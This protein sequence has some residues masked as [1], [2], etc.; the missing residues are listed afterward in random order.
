MHALSSTPTAPHG[1]A[2]QSWTSGLTAVLQR[3]WAAYLVWRS[4][5]AAIA[6]LA[7]MSDRELQDIGV[8]RCGIEQAVMEKP[9][10][11]AAFYR[12]TAARPGLEGI[13]P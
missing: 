6:E 5:Q 2:G 4:E 12:A 13:R 11:G 7:G 10:R 8:C 1:I 3:R 9:A